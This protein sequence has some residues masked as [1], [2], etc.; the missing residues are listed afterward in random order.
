MNNELLKIKFDGTFSDWMLFLS[1]AAIFVFYIYAKYLKSK[2]R[3]Y[4][5]RGNFRYH[6]DS[7]VHDDIYFEQ[8]RNGNYL[9]KVTIDENE[10]P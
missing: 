9:I 2:K 8:N 1:C 3:K 10:R 7:I 5:I 6:D 4:K